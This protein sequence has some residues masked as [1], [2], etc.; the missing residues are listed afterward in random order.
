MKNIILIAPPAAGKGTLANLIK[1]KYNM[2]NISVGQLLRDIDPNTELGQEIRRLQ[3]TRTLINDDTVREVLKL[4]LQQQD[5]KEKGFILDGFPRTVK[6][7]HILEELQQEL[8]FEDY[9]VVYLMV[10]YD[11][12]LKR[13]LGRLNCS[14]CKESY[15]IL[16]NFNNP[17]DDKTCRICGGS[18]E[19]RND[20]NEESFK[21]GFDMFNNDVLPTIDFYRETKG[22]IEVSAN[23]D[24][25]NDTFK[26]FEE[27]LIGRI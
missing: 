14:K 13:T 25:I 23:N 17:I 21:K 8:G 27:K 5:I 6:Q 1:S 10:D 15:N 4:R 19:R 11:L 24:D 2:I 16:T 26:E 3:A 20:D 22:V 18:L 7:A 12:A 9:E